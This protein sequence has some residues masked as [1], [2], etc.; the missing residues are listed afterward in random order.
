MNRT[1]YLFWFGGGGDDGGGGGGDGGGDGAGGEPVILL[2]TQRSACPYTLFKCET[3][4][5]CTT[6]H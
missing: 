1:I 3:F 2:H 5:K 4:L 6:K